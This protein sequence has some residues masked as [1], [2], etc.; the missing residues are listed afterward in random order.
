MI[1]DLSSLDERKGGKHELIL[2]IIRRF[3]STINQIWVNRCKRFYEQEQKEG[4]YRETKTKHKF[5]SMRKT[6]IANYENRKIDLKLKENN[7]FEKGMSLA[8]TSVSNFSLIV[9]DFDIGGA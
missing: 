5:V 2:I 6:E 4:I 8:L 7:V 9:F 1:K 3:K